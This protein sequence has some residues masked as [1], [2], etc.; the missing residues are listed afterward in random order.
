ML[1]WLHGSFYPW[2]QHTAGLSQLPHADLNWL[3]VADRVRYKLAVRVHRFLHN[4]VPKYLTDCWVTVS[5]V[6]GHQW[7]CSA[8]RCQLDVLCYQRTTLGRSLLLDQPS[9]IHFQLSSEMRLRTLS[10]SHWKHC[11]S[12]NISVLS[13]LEVSTTMRYINRRFTYFT[14][15]L[16]RSQVI[17]FHK[18]CLL[19][20]RFLVTSANIAI[21]HILLK[22]RFFGLHFCWRQYGSIFNHFYVIGPQNYRIR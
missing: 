1:Q 10:G 20:M 4:K 9:G 2:S 3:D 14:L 17:T 13:A 6:T 11:F 12:D 21:S 5:D 19:L 15:P 7:L 18:W 8:H 22:S 16:S